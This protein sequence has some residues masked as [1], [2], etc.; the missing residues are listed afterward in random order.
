MRRALS[1]CNC[2]GSRLRKVIL[3]Y[4]KNIPIHSLVASSMFPISSTW[5][6]TIKHVFNLGS[7]FSQVFAAA[8]KAPGF[9]SS[10]SVWRSCIRIICSSTSHLVLRHCT[11]PSPEPRM[12]QGR[13]NILPKFNT[14]FICTDD[15]QISVS[16]I[17]NFLHLYGTFPY[18]GAMN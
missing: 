1:R 15:L 8:S 18:N 2:N 13:L 14:I 3:K 16:I 9:F 6:Y 4:Y 17:S 10:Q 5:I 12:R 11:A 7:S